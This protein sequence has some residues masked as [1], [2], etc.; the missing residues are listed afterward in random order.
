MSGLVAVGVGLIAVMAAQNG[1]PVAVKFLIF[2][3]VPLPLGLVIAICA[4]V[5]L[6]GMAI[7]LMLWDW[8]APRS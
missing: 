6:V 2:Q 4:M 1:T 5:G 7:A 8:S 3:S